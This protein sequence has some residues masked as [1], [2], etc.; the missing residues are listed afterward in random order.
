MPDMI[1]VL[2][3]DDEPVLLQL[4]KR[5]LE[6]SGDFSITTID[7]ATAAL[8]LLHPGTFDAIISDYQ[9]PEMDGIT[10]LKKLKASGDATPFIIFTGRGR[11]EVVIEALNNGADFYIQKG[12]D[13]KSQFT[14]LAHKVRRAVDQRRVELAF[15]ASEEKYRNLIEHAN[16]VILV[17]QDG[18]LRLFNHRAVELTGYSEQEL[19]SMPFSAIIHPDDRSMV[20]ERFR[21]RLNTEETPSSYSFRVN[22]KDGS[23]SWVEISIVMID[24]EGRPAT[25]NFFT[26]ITERRQAEEA[27]KIQHDLSL[28]LNHCTNLDD[29]L[30]QILSAALQIEGLDAGGIYMADPATGDLDIVAHRGLSPQ[31]IAHTSHFD[32]TSAQVQR[33]CTGIPFYGRYSEIRQPGKDEIRDMEQ[34]NA[35][36][37][38]P[39]MHEGELISILNLAS[40]TMAEI[41]ISTRQ[42]L[43]TMAL[44]VGTAL[45]RI[46]SRK[47]L[48]A[49]EARFRNVIED[50]TE[51]ICRFLPDGTHVFVNE[52]YCRYFGLAR[53]NIIG[54]RFSPDLPREDREMVAR[55]LSTRTPEHPVETIE[56]RIIMPDGNI[57]WQ[58]WVDRAIFNSE[59]KL[60]EFQSVGRDITELKE[61]E[62][63]LKLKNEE[64]LASYEHI[65]LDEEQLRHQVE[66]I[67]AAQQAQRESEQKFRAI[68]NQSFQFIGL[69]TL[70]GI[71]ID[72]NQ[73]ALSSLGIPRDDVI[74]KPF[75][76]TA[77]WT[78][79]PELQEELKSAVHLAAQG[80]FI[81]FEATHPAIDGS[82]R[83]IDFS[84]KPVTDESGRIV[85]LIPEGRDITERKRAEESLRE[86]ERR[87]EDIINFLPDATFAID[88][89]GRVIAWNQAIEEMTGVRAEDMLGKGNYEYSIP[90][91][92]DR[93]PILIDL[94]MVE[95]QRILNNYLSVKKEGNALTAETDRATVGG[96]EVFLWGK[97]VLF[98]NSHGEVVG[99]I[100]S[101]R[102]IT[103]RKVTEEALREREETFRSLVQES[104]DGIVIADEEGTVIV[105]NNAAALITGI[106]G[107]E[108]LGRLY[109]DLVVSTVVPEHAEHDR[110]GR[111]RT[112][113]D[114]ELRTGI[115]E[116]FSRPLE[117]EI[118]RRDGERRYI[119]Q[120]A[121]PIRTAKGFRIGSIVRDITDRKKVEIDLE[122]SRNVYKAIFETTGA[123]TIIISEDTT[124]TLANSGFA[125]L[126][127]FSID[128]LEGKKSWTEFVV[129]EDLERMK[130]YHHDRR[131]DP[132]G[133]PVVYEFRFVNRYGE[134]RNCLNNVRLIPGT[135]QSVASVVDITG[136]KQAENALKQTLDQLTRN[137]QDLRESEGKYRTVFENTGTATVVLN[138]DS[139]I[140]LANNGFAQLSGLSKDEIE[141]KK[142]WTEFVIPDDMERMRAQHLLRRQEREKALTRYEF[143]FITKSR[144]IR[145]IYLFIDVIPGTKKSIASLLDI[146]ERKQAEELYKTIFENT[147]TAMIFVEENS[148]I[149][150]VNEEME[151]I[152]GYSREEI[153]GLVKWSTLVAPEDL[154]KMQKYQ[155]I[156]WKD[157]SATPRDYEFRF[158]HKNGEIRDAALSVAIIPGTKKS[159]VSLRDITELKKLD[160]QVK[161]RTDQVE[162][163]LRQKDEFIA[164]AGHDLKTPLTPI[165]ALLPHIYKKEQDPE[166]RELLA[167]VM[168]DAASM[169]H[170]IADILTLA[171][172]NRPYTTP[173]TREM[174]LADEIEKGVIKHAWMAEKRGIFIESTAGPDTRIWITPL[175]LES[176][177]DNLI[178]NSI[179]YTPEG[180]K[181]TISSRMAEGFI[182][183]SVT[184]TGIGLNPEET[185][186]IFDEF[187]KADM[188]RHDRDS[189]GLGLTIVSRIA[190]LY[191]GNVTAESPGKGCGSTFTI[192]LPRR[193]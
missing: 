134:I 121:F 169:K 10:F 112:R 181:V 93:R 13:P 34:V 62:M 111:I 63:A 116:S 182:S 130:Q 53:E 66:A 89:E 133:A 186:R 126:S 101:I 16:E 191:G 25:L 80:E 90:F 107:N 75:W 20:I 37:S 47:A 141:G 149:S 176:I 52:A 45:V 178:S 115:S 119:Q 185:T 67:T 44:Q 76:E 40:H 103:Q 9:M 73:S 159:V 139:I 120:F 84:L 15:R 42:T 154:E 68:F 123:A 152:W 118:I 189:S 43:E 155:M 48:E 88:Y 17:A 31:F 124:I 12:G 108:A 26:D 18:M 57:R 132:S 137:E 129:P 19:M 104:S 24:W 144:D 148:V 29:A 110:I 49:S 22:S 170:L 60:E 11:E 175:H 41:P 128:E 33:A 142:S 125:K 54:S 21:K 96:K 99:A 85:Y 153:E 69:I 162:Q 83:A 164:Q 190:H 184:D 55:V 131:D 136:L 161:E 59:G 156:R 122:K 77:W 177:L 114:K 97:S 6:Q 166:L 70:E 36:A 5:F 168:S 171:Q 3:V 27:L 14:E 102:D 81:R 179:R 95:D 91:Y 32:A 35:L 30:K 135:T 127:G 79:S 172:L 146:T 140:E 46:R 2:Y 1:R 174:V 28:A 147:G 94:V 138:E 23:I 167:M 64:L 165:I 151:K 192:T 56:Q 188:S 86:T 117:D 106:P 78:H 39:F 92:G 51:F 163:L 98:K 100:E 113:I 71:L 158:I 180:G 105:W 61:R 173:D 187:F 38:I 145:F 7:S 4:G 193:I 183:I 109:A 143:R 8:D 74:G 50:Q 157:P 82:I 160:R 65:A 58:R 72:A 87:L 150:H